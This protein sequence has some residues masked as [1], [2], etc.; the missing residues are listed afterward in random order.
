[1]TGQRPM[2]DPLAAPGHR[3]EEG[4][5]RAIHRPMPPPRFPWQETAALGLLA[6]AIG[7]VFGL[8]PGMLLLAILWTPTAFL[9]SVLGGA[10]ALGGAFVV[11]MILSHLF[12]RCVDRIQASL[13]GEA[14]E[15]RSAAALLWWMQN[16]PDAIPKEGSWWARAQWRTDPQGV[17]LDTLALH[18]HIPDDDPRQDGGKTLWYGYVD[19]KIQGAPSHLRHAPAASVAPPAA[20][21]KWARWHPYLHA[22]ST[23]GAVFALGSAHARMPLLAAATR[24]AATAFGGGAGDGTAT[25]HHSGT[26]HTGDK[27]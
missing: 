2:D 22:P 6:G 5:F 18:E 11:A 4:L 14:L 17:R 16:R 19:C 3:A 8:L 15:A 1:M 12:D 9:G 24:Q 20:A 13:Q 21:R 10:L 27:A 25:A 7:A 26:G 23:E